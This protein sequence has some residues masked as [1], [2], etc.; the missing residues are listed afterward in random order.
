MIWFHKF[1]LSYL[2]VVLYAPISFFS[3]LLASLGQESLLNQIL[4]QAFILTVCI[5][6]LLVGFSKWQILYLEKN[7]KPSILIY[8][9]P[10]IVIGIVRAVIVSSFLNYSMGQVHESLYSRIPVSIVATFLWLGLLTYL[11]NQSTSYNKNFTLLFSSAVMETTKQ[12]YPNGKIQL[13]EVPEIQE[14]REELNGLLDFDS[15][16][17]NQLERIY[18]AANLI[19][20]H[21][22]LVLRP[23][24][25]RLWISADFQVP[26]VRFWRLL[27]DSL[28]DLKFSIFRVITP[29]AT[30]FF[31][32][33]LPFFPP[34]KSLIISLTF[35][36][37][38]VFPLLLGRLLLH[39]SFSGEVVI[40]FL[41]LLYCL[42]PVPLSNF[43]L[44]YFSYDF[45]LTNV[46]LIHSLTALTGCSLILANSVSYLIRSDRT[47]ILAS[48]PEALRLISERKYIASYVHN[49]M[50]SQLTSIALQLEK[51]RNEGISPEVRGA[52]E[53]L[54]SLINREIS[55]DFVPDKS[56]F[57]QQLEE[58]RESWR[59]LVSI[60]FQGFSNSHIK[61]DE[62]RLLL[63]FIEEVITNSVRHGGANE[64][65]F[66]IKISDER[67][68]LVVSH[69]GKRPIVEGSGLGT[70]WL[71]EYAG[72]KWSISS[73]HERT[74]LTAEIERLI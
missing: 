50:Q 56:S 28:H 42:I 51:A 58:L 23:L 45:Q 6:F 38:L 8:F 40:S 3:Y 65:S 26:K 25:H 53:R 5:E 68:I 27:R 57:Q 64:I 1:A 72:R 36:A 30:L 37:S 55:N 44:E 54:G 69:D 70:T 9:S 74:T 12:E 60:D 10:W 24:S 43:L 21:I 33:A 67:F 63:F 47:S 2:A 61:L 29:W 18:L 20:A 19:K 14:F 48:I 59:G 46:T 66:E 62:S 15:L 41:F 34:E 52:L 39:L 73:E 49:S 11:I 16:D 35:I 32:G 13:N 31:L 17:E 7:A 71:D 22:Q 4:I